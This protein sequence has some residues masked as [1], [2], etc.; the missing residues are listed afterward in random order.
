MTLFR[1]SLLAVFL[2]LVAGCDPSRRP[3]NVLL[4]TFDTTRADHLS[5]YGGPAATPNLEALARDGILFEQAFSPVPIT[6]PAHSSLL[7]GKVPFTHGV[8]D[9]GLFRLSDE[10][11]TLADVLGDSGYATG[12]AVGAFPLIAKFGTAQGFGFFDDEL[13]ESLEDFWGERILPRKKLFFDERPAGLVNDA[14]IP[15]IEDNVDRPF[16]AWAHYF[17]PHLPHTPPAPFDER[18]AHDLYAGEIAYADESLGALVRT[19]QEAGVY[20]D[21]IIVVTADHGESRGEHNEATH[22]LLAYNSTLRVPLIIKPAAGFGT[23]GARLEERVGLVDVLPTLLDWIGIDTPEGVQGRSLA[24]AVE[25]SESPQRALYAETL[26]PRL[27]H[28]WGE[29]RA[30]FLGDLKYIHGPRPEL[31][32]LSRD[33]RELADLSADRPEEAAEMR[34]NLAAYLEREAVAGIDASVA[35][36]PD[37]ARRLASLGYVVGAGLRA[38]PIDEVLRDDGDAPQDRA[39]TIGTY[40]SAKQFM[41]EARWLEAREQL[42]R[43]LRLDPDNGHYIDLLATVESRLGRSDRALELLTSL[44]HDAVLPPRQTVLESIARLLLGRGDRR[45][46]AEALRDAQTIERTAQ[47]QYSL[48]RIYEDLGETD[49]QRRF[50]ER[51]LELDPDFVPT[52]LASAIR[53]ALDDDRRSA[54]R[55]FERALELHPF[56]ARS[57]FNFGVFLLGDMDLEG[58]IQRFSRAVELDPNY[59]QARGALVASLIEGDQEDD[60]LEQ[61]L[62]L[63]RRAPAHPQTQLAAQLLEIDL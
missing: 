45:G 12:A 17:D 36:D 34:S 50:L 16:F 60:A 10:Q 25:G 1:L 20:D 41:F 51:S 24:R 47:G 53:D 14:L 3:P 21:T 52:L 30:L 23:G 26:S 62:E 55:R 29:L 46:A 6:L 33:P 4:V 27:S 15:W 43:L 42:E 56:F 11:Q 18:Y 39:I 19:L 28:G 57:H 44:P 38:A 63:A 54:R 48:A 9:N 32:D 8:R 58:A 49:L 2:A 40:S 61:Y 59:H 5:A 13:T 35:L 31:Y 37:T 22:S 7:T